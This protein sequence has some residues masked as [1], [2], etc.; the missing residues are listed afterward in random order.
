MPL[1]R[2]VPI[3][4]YP[5]R[6][7]TALT[8]LLI[9]LLGAGCG[10]TVAT[11]EPARLTLAAS[12]SALPLARE[13]AAAYH[14]AFPHITVDLL[15]LAN[16]AA[17]AQAVLAGRADAA[18]AAG[19]ND[20]PAGLRASRLA[21]DALA[22][23]VHRDRSLDNLTGQQA[24]DVF[25]GLL[26]TWDA[27]EESAEAG[28][29]QVITREPG[30]GPRTALVAALLGARPLTPTAIV[31]PDDGQVLAR[32]AGDRNAIAVLPA[33]WLDGQVRALTIDGRGPDWV[34]R[35]WPGYPLE[36]PIYLLTAGAPQ[37]DVAALSGFLLGPAG[38]QVV[39]RRY[40]PAPSQP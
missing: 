12:S 2:N 20:A 21:S 35:Q 1:R 7:L 39:S 30:A 18:L 4:R 31:L 36:L 38:Q 16:E 3:R 28:T 40:A 17:A 13:L 11:P 9:G 25:H 8:A 26:R 29:V 6:L 22:V 10:T 5:R 19:L 34:A 37:A 23:V 33:A 15:P 32:V 14:A 24:R 27:L